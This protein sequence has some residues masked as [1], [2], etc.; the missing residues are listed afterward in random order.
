MLFNTFVLR[1]ILTIANQW[2]KARYIGTIDHRN[3]DSEYF[4]AWV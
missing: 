4:N 3:T 1:N 2:V